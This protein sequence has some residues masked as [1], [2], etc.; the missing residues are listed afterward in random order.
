MTTTTSASAIEIPYPESTDL[1]LQL[2]LGPCRLHFT[3]SDGPAWISG[4]YDD[5]TTSLPIQIR[6]GPVTTISQRMDLSSFG[7]LE[8]PR[9]DLAIG[10]ARPFALDIQ[11]GASETTFDLGGL[12]ISRLSLKTGAGKFEVDFSEPNPGAMTVMELGAGAGSLTARNLA[13]A[14]FSA[15]RVSGGVSACLLDFSGTLRRDAS[16]R[17]DA[18]V[19]SVDLIIP[20]TT[21]ATIVTKSFASAR[22]AT[23]AFTVRGEAYYT[24]AAVAGTGPRLEL[25]VSL[26]LGALNLATTSDLGV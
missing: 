10:R 12:P 17:I 2:R 9:L 1:T 4:T 26:A 25:E 14:N 24:P 7:G 8:M 23:A 15:M 20:A 22:R 19:G 5:P 21:A 16:G 6:T 13:N 11:A 3:P 18:G